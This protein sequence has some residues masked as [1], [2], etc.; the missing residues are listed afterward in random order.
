[1]ASD[2]PEQ[3][4]TPKHDFHTQTRLPG[5]TRE[6]VVCDGFRVGIGDVHL[7]RLEYLA[8]E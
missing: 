8:V 6:G 1:M 3:G 4:S 5:R 7:P 2:R